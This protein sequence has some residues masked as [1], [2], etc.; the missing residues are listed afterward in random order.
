MI[1]SVFSGVKLQL[2]VVQFTKNVLFQNRE[3]SQK[4]YDFI[5]A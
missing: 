1:M 4:N 5:F 3:Q 2:G